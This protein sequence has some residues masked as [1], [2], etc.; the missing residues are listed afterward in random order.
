MHTPWDYSHFPRV[1][2]WWGGVSFSSPVGSLAYG[3]L[4]GNN[5]ERV[6]TWSAAWGMHLENFSHDS[7]AWW[8]P[9]P[10]SLSCLPT[11]SLTSVLDK[12]VVINSHSTGESEFL[13]LLP[14]PHPPVPLGA[15]APPTDVPPLPPIFSAPAATLALCSPAIPTQPHQPAGPSPMNLAQATSCHV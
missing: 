15:E 11:V 6:W 8:S 4:C 10:S 5:H 7:R 14:V 2:H 13:S 9:E 3:S 12:C 1:H